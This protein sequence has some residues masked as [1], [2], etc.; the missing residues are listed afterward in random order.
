MAKNK[1]GRPSSYTEEAGKKICDLRT[2]GKSLRKICKAKGMPSRP[3]VR[4]WLLDADNDIFRAQYAQACEIDA[5]NMFD[6]LVALSDECKEGFQSQALKLRID[7]RKWV[8]SKR[9]PKKYGDRI[10]Q[11]LTGANGGPIKEEI[12]LKTV[13]VFDQE[14]DADYFN[15]VYD[16][17]MGITKEED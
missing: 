1:T 3:T 2:K 17:E 16:R 8:L 9:L 6:E 12:D 15:K 14:Q 13:V 4:R 11:E 7:T 10:H 5:E